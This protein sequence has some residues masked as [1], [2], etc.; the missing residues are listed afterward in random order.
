[1]EA[2]LTNIAGTSSDLQDVTDNGA[3]T[4]RTIQAGGLKTDLIQS[5]SQASESFIDL[6]DDLWFAGLSTNVLTL[7][8]KSH[9]VFVNDTNSNGTTEN[10]SFYT[11]GTT[12]ANATKLFEIQQGGDVV[13]YGNIIAEDAEVHVGD[14]SGDSWTR[15]KHAQA[16][17]YGFDWTHDNATV[18]VNEQ[19]TTNEALVLGDTNTASTDSGLFGISYST[20]GGANW[21]KKLDLRGNGDLYVGSSGTTRVLTTADEGSGNGIDAD[22][23]DGYHAT[24]FFIDGDTV[25]N[26]ANDDGLVYND[27][28]NLMYIKADGTNYQIIDTRGGTFTGTITTSGGIAMNNT[29]LTGVNNIVINDAGAGEGIEWAGGNLWKIYESPNNLSNASGN[30]QFVTNATRRM[31]L[32][33]SGNLEVTGGKVTIVEDAGNRPK[34]AFQETPGTDS[35]ILEYNGVGGGAGNY[36]SFYSTA[37]NWAGLGEGLNYIPENGRVGIGTTSPASKLHVGTAALGASGG[38]PSIIGSDGVSC[39]SGSRIAVDT[40]YYSHGYMQFSSSWGSESRYG[41]YGY[42]GISLNTR[43]GS[44]LVV[45]GDSNNVGIGTTSPSK[46]LDVAGSWILD[47]INGGHFEN[48]TYG[49]QLDI[50]ELTS[51][52]WARANRIVTSDSAGSVFFGVLGGVTTTNYAYWNI[53]N[54]AS[55]S[56]NYNSSNG[57]VLTRAGNVGIGTTSPVGKLNVALPADSNGNVSAWGSN[58]VVFT[59]G[60]TSTSQGLGFSVHDVNNT[61]TISS[62]TPAVTWSVL[63][64]RALAHFFYSTGTN[65]GLMQDTAANVGIGTTSPE[66]KVHIE[67]STNDDLLLEI[68][69][70]N[71]GASS[72]AGLLLRGQGNNFFLRNLGDGTSLPN[73]TEFKSTAGGG[74]FRFNLGGNEV[75]RMTGT[76]VPLQVNHINSNPTLFIG[77]ASG[78][79]NIKGGAS[80]DGHVIIDSSNNSHGVWLQ[81]YT[82]GNV[83]MATGGGKVGIGTTTVSE[84][85]TI[86]GGISLT[87][88]I[89]F[90][91][92]N[93]DIHLSRGSYITFYENASADHSISSR[94]GAFSESDDIRINSYGSVLINLDS[95]NNNT[96]SANLSVGRHGSSGT[97]SD[98][99]FVVDGETGAGTFKGDVIAFGSPSDISLKENIKP[100]KGALDKVKKTSGCNL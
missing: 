20:D 75:V 46:K 25:L 38:T 74:N 77:R 100:I 30:L 71:T 93:G 68:D 40:G 62:L 98:W 64:Y 52:G 28:N 43:S 6:D 56:T 95:N 39:G 88:N 53:G 55:N 63:E 92:S 7:S 96:S 83:Y 15:I 23:L 17:G 9:M 54:A 19:G 82:G 57:V 72:S 2:V 91:S 76:G 94:N 35:F 66:N 37:T 32:D 10:F 80:G 85:L 34:L 36:V 44:G 60:G 79:A 24:S 86:S 73:S 67:Q 31:T 81:N 59:R 26:M 47:G 13:A 70:Q 90:G 48:Y 49:S 51:G 18:I 8:S 45:R 22:T 14:V 78:V 11:Q 58:Q 27:T 12:D 41:L 5:A 89:N 29:N 3:T 33:T 21:T 84:K 16:D 4:T 87:G 65:I 42:Y 1:M 97:I 50:S 99:L 61:A 69:N